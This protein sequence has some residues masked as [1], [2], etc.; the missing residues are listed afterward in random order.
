MRT[1][2]R[3]PDLN[4]TPGSLSSP[5]VK[6]AVRGALTSSVGAYLVLCGSVLFVSIVLR[7]FVSTRCGSVASCSVDEALLPLRLQWR[8]V[9][10]VARG[11]ALCV[12][13]TQR[14]VA[15][16]RDR[17]VQDSR[18]L[19]CFWSGVAAGGLL[20]LSPV[21]HENRSELGSDSLF[22]LSTVGA[23]YRCVS[24]L[25]F[26]LARRWQVRR[27]GRCVI[28]GAPPSPRVPFALHS[29]L[30][31]FGPRPPVLRAGQR[32]HELCRN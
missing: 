17:G 15:E 20:V 21:G 10:S 9:Q 31:R 4:S 19:R 13:A 28:R 27:I 32:V 18:S 3:R 14:C 24:R 16:P 2:P 25:T 7:C 8:G 6:D 23:H 22:L 11:S 29:C 5:R 26:V 12:Q 1:Q 30:R